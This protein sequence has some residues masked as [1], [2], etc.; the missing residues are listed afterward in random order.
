MTCPPSAVSTR[1]ARLTRNVSAT[2]GKVAR[3][4][5]WAMMERTLPRSS[6][7]ST[8]E[9]DTSMILRLGSCPSRQAMCA[10]V[11][12][13]DFRWRGGTV[14]MARRQAPAAI[15]ATRWHIA[16]TCHRSRLGALDPSRMCIA[17]CAKEV[18]SWRARRNSTPGSCTSE[19]S[20]L[21]ADAPCRLV[22]WGLI[23]VSSGVENLRHE[24]ALLFKRL[25]IRGGTC[26]HGQVLIQKPERGHL[27]LLVAR[28]C[29]LKHFEDQRFRPGDRLGVRTP[30]EL[31]LGRSE[32]LHQGLE[33][34]RCP[35]DVPTGSQT[36]R[37]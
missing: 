32:F 19:P 21:R 30:G 9:Y 17:I 16:W 34:C 8:F 31:H 14:T 26:R 2:P 12:T 35:S 28:E 10:T 5:G 7:E 22:G 27:R 4:Q 33:V 11:T 13:V 25:R 3:Y 18:K 36:G 1:S 6:F 15:S 20:G 23:S 24:C 37:A 29:A